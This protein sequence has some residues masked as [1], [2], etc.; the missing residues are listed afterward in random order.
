MGLNERRIKE[1]IETQQMPEMLK[2]YAEKTSG[3]TSKLVLQIDWDS[4]DNN[5]AAYANLTSVW[6]QPFFGIEAV[7]K[8]KL[9]QDAVRESVKKIVIRNVKTPGEVKAEFKGG[10]LIANFNLA[11]GT[12]GS[13]GWTDFQTVLESGL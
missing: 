7:C 12:N 8:D 1:D 6:E 3:A 9:G 11:E 13:T 5:P 10:E 2:T 4:F